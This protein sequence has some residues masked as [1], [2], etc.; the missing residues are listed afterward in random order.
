MGV[1]P[2]FMKVAPVMRALRSPPAAFDQVL[3]HTGQHRD[4]ATSQVSFQGS[5][6]L[7]PDRYLGRDSGTHAEQTGGS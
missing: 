5:A 2:N 7:E 6:L 1:Q 4:F 3:I